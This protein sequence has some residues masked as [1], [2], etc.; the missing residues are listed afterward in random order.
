MKL[1]KLLSL[2]AVVACAYACSN[3]VTPENAM[4]HIQQ[5]PEYQT[6]FYAQLHIGNIIVSGKDAPNAEKVVKQKYKKLID[7]GMV[8]VKKESGN[9]WRTAVNVALTSDGADVCDPRRT[10]GEHAYVPVCI[11]KPTK[12]VSAEQTSDTTL[13]CKFII[14]QQNITLFGDFL[15]YAPNVEHT[16]SYTF[17]NK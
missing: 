16:M 14:E 15:G 12:L 1:I 10:D 2:I 4:E 6:P 13:L 8:E 17:V 9:V 5:L 3:K 7:A 11:M